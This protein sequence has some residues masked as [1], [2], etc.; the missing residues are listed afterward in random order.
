M[1]S[2][3]GMQWYGGELPGIHMIKSKAFQVLIAPACCAGGRPQANS[4][5]SS[6]SGDGRRQGD[7]GTTVL[8]TS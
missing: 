1:Y 3:G 2:V 8:R 7:P 5:S 4:L 6:T